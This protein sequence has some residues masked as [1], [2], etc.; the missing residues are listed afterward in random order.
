VL[1]PYERDSRESNV[2]HLRLLWEHRRFLGRVT[3]IGVLIS[4][5]VSLLVSNR[6]EST[7]RLMPP[8]S[9]SGASLS[10][11]ASALSGAPASLGNLAGE[12]LG[13]KS[14]SDLVVG[15]LTSRTVADSVIQ[16]LDLHKVYGTRRME[17]TRRALAKH[18]EASI[19]RKSQIVTITVTDKN[20][21][22]AAALTQAY[23]DE[24]N[25]VMADVSTSSARRERVF[26]EGR[27]QSVS[28]DLEDAEKTFSQFASR[29]TTID[30]KEQGKAIVDAATA[31]QGKLIA[32][33][34][35]LQGL[36]QIYTDNNVRVR[37]VQA[38]ITELENQLQKVGGKGEGT[39]LDTME[40]N[41]ALYPSIRKLPLLGVSYE[42]L[43]RR[44]RIEE[45][46]LETL[47]REYELAKV[48]E[49]K[50]IPA[51][52]VLDAPN[53]PDK[54]SYPSRTLIVLFGT[55]LAL[56]LSATWVFAK[57]LWERTEPTD[58]LKAFAQEVVQTAKAFIPLSSHNGHG[59]RDSG[60][61][62]RVVG[63]GTRYLSDKDELSK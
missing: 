13:L 53:I 47:T 15:V 14:T 36:R 3:G 44:T 48:Q 57:A 33:R 34:S 8:D 46:V 18:T 1:K 62:V 2:E 32:A 22:R 41:N 54:K 7:A 58:P 10:T 11:A 42:D 28:Q 31:L 27:L 6:Y 59:T 52:K 23:V 45:A 29:N 9:P 24:L 26:L 39:S 61:G 56:S 63:P 37:S 40:T 38:Q 20:P 19:D 21:R 49:A 55:V 25:R 50:E 35:D 51:V 43:Y 30:I 5:I 12:A 4:V 60:L 16:K 17:D